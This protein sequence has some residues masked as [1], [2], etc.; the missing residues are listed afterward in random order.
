MNISISPE[1]R[2]FVR[3]WQHIQVMSLLPAVL[4]HPVL[5]TITHT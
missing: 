1:S 3:R 2:N 4:N 5:V